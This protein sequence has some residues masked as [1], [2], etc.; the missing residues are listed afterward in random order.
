MHELEGIAACVNLYVRRVAKERVSKVPE[1][2]EGPGGF[3]NGWKVLDSTRSFVC[4]FVRVD[5]SG[6]VWNSGRVTRNT[7]VKYF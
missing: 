6:R 2:R 1:S 7:F 4:S 3:W 5:S